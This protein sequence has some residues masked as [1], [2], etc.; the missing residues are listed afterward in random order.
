MDV[1]QF[2]GKEHWGL[3]KDCIDNKPFQVGVMIEGEIIAGKGGLHGGASDPLGALRLLMQH[4]PKGVLLDFGSGAGEAVIYGAHHGWQ[5]YGI[6]FCNNAYGLSIRNI[7]SAE[8]AGYITQGLAKIVHGNFFPN[9]FQVRRHDDREE[10][11]FR[12]PIEKHT[13][14]CE[15]G[16]PYIDLGVGLDQVDLFFH[17][18]VERRDNILR[19]VSERA[20]S[21]AKL[22]FRAT[23]SD[24]FEVPQNLAEII[25]GEPLTLYEKI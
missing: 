11:G 18:Q 22:L 10:D 7:Q 20:K 9:D 5:S 16:N 23:I 14:E 15:A 21:G 2:W 6:E 19:L 17:Y 12:E 8:E 1:I 24:S 13:R 25:S 4:Y 3:R